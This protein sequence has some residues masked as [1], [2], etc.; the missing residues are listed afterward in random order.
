MGER[1]AVEM[2]S[3]LQVSYDM[4]SIWEHPGRRSSS[5]TSFCRSEMDYEWRDCD[6]ALNDTRFNAVDVPSLSDIKNPWRL[7]MVD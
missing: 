4:Q 2:I 3:I 6:D 7:T 1:V 5:K